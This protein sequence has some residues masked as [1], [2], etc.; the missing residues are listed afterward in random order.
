MEDGGAGR[1]D[2]DAP[3]SWTMYVSGRLV[4]GQPTTPAQVRAS[5]RI[6]SCDSIVGFTPR[7]MGK[8]FCGTGPGLCQCRFRI[9]IEA[10]IG[11]TIPRISLALCAGLS[12]ASAGQNR[13]H[14]CFPSAH[15][16]G[17]AMIK[18]RIVTLGFGTGQQKMALERWTNPKPQRR[19]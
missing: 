13:Q 3:A 15:A 17:T 1:R 10:C 9:A 4:D 7:L 5:V 18:L 12:S 11:L 6:C 14:N 8:P 16:S 2:P 19:T